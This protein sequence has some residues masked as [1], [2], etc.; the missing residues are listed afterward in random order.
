LDQFSISFSLASLHSLC[1]L[2][3]QQVYQLKDN[4][5]QPSK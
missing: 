1:L 2:A 4:Q 5:E 3:Y